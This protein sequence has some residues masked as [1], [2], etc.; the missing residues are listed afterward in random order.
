MGDGNTGVTDYKLK[1]DVW[2]TKHQKNN[3]EKNKVSLTRGIKGH[4]KGRCF[5]FFF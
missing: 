2:K 3:N 1:N 4:L 5:L